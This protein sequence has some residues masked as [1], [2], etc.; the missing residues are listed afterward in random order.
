MKVAILADNQ[1]GF[2]QPMADG[3][4]K[5]LD[6]AGVTAEVFPDG[7]AILNYGAL[8]GLHTG[9][10]NLLKSTVNLAKPQHFL[11]Q[12]HA[13]WFEVK[14]FEVKLTQFDL[15]V[16]V[17]NIPDAFLA[18]RLNR[19]ERIRMQT[20]RPIVLYQNYYLATRGQWSRKIKDPANYGGGFGLER[21]DWYLSASAVSE[22]PLSKEPHPYSLIGHDLNDGSLFAQADKPFTVLLDFNRKGFE[23]Y[24]QI[25]IQAL[26]ETNTEYTQL[27]G[28]YSQKEIRQLYRQ[29]SALFLSF[30]ESF[31]LPVVENQLCGN[32]IFAPHKNWLP[33]HYINKSV[34]ETGEGDLG[35]NFI[36]YDNE[37]NKLKLLIRE[38]RKHYQPEDSVAYFKSE[39]PAL[40]HGDLTELKAFLDKVSRGEITGDTHRHHATLNYGIIC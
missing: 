13:S 35:S 40:Y 37:L 11:L 5:M 12:Q 39:Y 22:F 8:N 24:R 16:V 2:I 31:G 1:P 7:L 15:I 17:C 23:D 25:Q 34:H 3:L 20:D 38:C 19:I 18:K 36:I 9:F 29:C 10:K 26:K 14:H 28:R 33:S 4:K 32:Y 21:Y 27:S 6:R 30:R